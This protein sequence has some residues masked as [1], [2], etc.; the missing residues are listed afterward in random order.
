MECE[1]VKT[2]YKELIYKLR[3]AAALSGA[4]AI[5]MPFSEGSAT[6]QLYNAAADAI[7]EL[8]YK[9]QKALSDS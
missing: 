6:A 8:D 2:K 3:E 4:L 7:E 5:I 9:C 1:N